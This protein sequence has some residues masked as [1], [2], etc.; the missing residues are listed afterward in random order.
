MGL[1]EVFFGSA[2][3]QYAAYAILA[4]IFTIC[5]TILFSGTDMTI[6]SRLLMILFVI[7]T[8]IPSIFLI[9][10]EITCMVS[11]GTKD[12]NWWCWLYA[13][14]IAVFII[15]YCIFVVIISLSSL[16]T[17]NT[18]MEKLTISE[19]NNI[20]S[21]DSSNQYARDMLLTNT[22]EQKEQFYIEH[23]YDAMGMSPKKNR[24]LEGFTGT[25]TED[26]Q[27][28]NPSVQLNENYENSSNLPSAPSASSAPS[29]PSASSAPSVPSVQSARSAQSEPK[30]IAASSDLKKKKVEETFEDEKGVNEKDIED[31]DDYEA[32]SNFNYARY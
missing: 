1:Y 6:G 13:W 22:P 15:I 12:K 31:E 21:P 23:F 27:V 14:I 18:A 9:L 28:A 26:N 30:P 5:M 24:E 7:L 29:A 11:G 3:S 2:Q 17:Y 10:F 20:M 16:F 4:A 32:F 25:T 19:N 8:L